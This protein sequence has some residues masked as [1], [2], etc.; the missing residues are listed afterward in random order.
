M[1]TFVQAKFDNISLFV[2]MSLLAWMIVHFVHHN[3]NTT[4]LTWAEQTFTTV[5]GAYIGLTQ[6]ARI[7]WNNKPT[8]GGTNGTPV[9][10]KVESPVVPGTTLPTY[11]K[12]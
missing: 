11:P 7:A 3:D 8:N 2:A 12:Q 6:A 4:A 9:I 5:L 10:P 1:W